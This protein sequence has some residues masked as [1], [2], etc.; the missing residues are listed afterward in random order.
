MTTHAYEHYAQFR[1]ALSIF[2]GMCEGL[3]L[4][5]AIASESEGPIVD[6]FQHQFP[7]TCPEKRVSFSDLIGESSMI[8]A[9]CL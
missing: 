2:D 3:A 1:S 4:D 5:I 9:R 8:E 6:F 7:A